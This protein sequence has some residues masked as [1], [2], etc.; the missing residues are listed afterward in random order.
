MLAVRSDEALSRLREAH[1]VLRAEVGGLAQVLA[2]DREEAGDLSVAELVEIPPGL[3][4]A[5]AACLAEGLEAGLDDAA[6]SGWQVLPNLPP[7]PLPEPATPLDRLVA[8]PPALRRA[9]S[10]AGLV[11]EADGRALQAL[12]RPGQCLVTRTGGLWRWDGYR[13]RSGVPSQAAL[14]L[15]QRTRLHAARGRL[16]EAEAGLPPAVAQAAGQGVQRDRAEEAMRAARTRR[17]L[18]EQGLSQARAAENGVARRDAEGRARLDALGPQLDRARA[19]L[20]EAEAGLAQ[21]Q[22]A[23]DPLP[24]P[25]AL[26]GALT[27]AAADEAGAAAAAAQARDARRSAEATLSRVR[28]AAA[29][30]LAAHA[31]SA[32]LRQT[33]RPLLD[34]AVD[35]AAAALAARTAARDGLEALEGGEG[36]PAALAA[37]LRMRRDDAADADKDVAARR[38]RLLQARQALAERTSARDRLAA[39]LLEGRSRLE[40]LATR[41]ALAA[42]ERDEASAALRVAVATAAD[43]PD[44]EPLGRRAD[45]ARLALS[46]AR[47]A[48]RSAEAAC[49]ALA[50]EQAALDARQGPLVAG[51]AEWRGRREAAMASMRAATLRLEAAQAARDVAAAAPAEAERRAQALHASIDAAEAALGAAAE[52]LGRAELAAR[53]ALAAGRAGEA[54]LGEAREAATRAEVRAEQ[55][56][57]A[58]AQLLA[59][60]PLPPGPGPGPG[61]AGRSGA[62]RP[63][64]RRRGRPAPAHGAAHTATATRSA[65]STC[66]PSSNWHEAE[67]RRRDRARA[68]RAEAAIAR[69]RGQIGHLNREGRERL[70][71]VFDAVDGHFRRL[72]ARMFER[73]PGAAGAGGLG[74]SARRRDGDLRA[75]AGQEA[76]HAVAA[77]GRRTGADR[78]RR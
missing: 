37:T 24:T 68:R 73:R 74:R 46:E 77:V 1:G 53:A 11:E 30:R 58:L 22:A 20:R 54:A 6:P 41:R 26:A 8:A 15:L 62:G 76:G 49:A 10:Q 59:D 34:R 63:V 28:A 75:A 48:E 29:A 2:P 38:E 14:R 31:E 61:S 40:A 50:A 7:A 19:A 56:Q 78:A 23:W 18:A 36:A 32:V 45:A 25:E 57:A 12:L 33:L 27:R 64:R 66:A 67:T 16:A 21:A 4:A 71:A 5:L 51:L 44:P 72:F 52:R 47:A 3:E 65:R 55:A 42:A 39:S 43:L 60:T 35:E 9:L 69:L 17:T 70:V 13:V